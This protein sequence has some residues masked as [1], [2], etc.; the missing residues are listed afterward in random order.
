MPN[1]IPVVPMKKSPRNTNSSH[2]SEQS[3]GGSQVSNAQPALQP[4]IS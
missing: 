1:A 2:N 4:K 3:R